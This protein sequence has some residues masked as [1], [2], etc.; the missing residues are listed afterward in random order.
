MKS[1][2][3]LAE[4]YRNSKNEMSEYEVWLVNYKTV[5]TAPDLVC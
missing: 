2:I 3:S 4:E 1:Q 5:F